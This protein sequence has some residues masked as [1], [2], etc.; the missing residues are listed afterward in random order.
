[1]VW[2]EERGGSER[3]KVGGGKTERGGPPIMKGRRRV[4]GQNSNTEGSEK[5]TGS[6]NG[7]I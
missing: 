5:V 6:S 4:D 7:N 1:M 2:E 3:G